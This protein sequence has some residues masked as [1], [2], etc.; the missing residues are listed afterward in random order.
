MV[1][2]TRRAALGSGL[3]ALAAAASAVG[4]TAGAAASVADLVPPNAGADEHLIALCREY[5]TRDDLHRRT[6]AAQTLFARRT[7]PSRMQS[8]RDSTTSP[9][10]TAA[11]WANLRI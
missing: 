1:A 3:I 4:I 5:V 10:R 7:R 6:C 11:S 8:G 9:A 2:T